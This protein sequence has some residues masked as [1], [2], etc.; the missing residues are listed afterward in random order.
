VVRF[1]GPLLCSRDWPENG[2]EKPSASA[3]IDA[4]PTA[5]PCAQ[6]ICRSVDRCARVISFRTRIRHPMSGLM[7]R[8]TMRSWSTLSDVVAVVMP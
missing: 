1:A 2:E 5:S 6:R 4:L 3:S 7:P 8:R